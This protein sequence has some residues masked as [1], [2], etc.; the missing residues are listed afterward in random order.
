M[1]YRA[2]LFAA[3]VFY[4]GQS[5]HAFQEPDPTDGTWHP[6]TAVLGGQEFPKAVLDSIVL[7]L[8]GE[9]YAVTVNGTP[10]KGTCVVDSSVTPHRM[11]ITGNNLR[12]NGFRP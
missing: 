2:M 1:R 7:K 12:C 4:A 9:Q 3:V 11:T 8:N 5:V 10:D 6:V